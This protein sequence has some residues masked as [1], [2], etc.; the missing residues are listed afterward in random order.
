MLA[1][2]TGEVENP[3]AIGWAFQGN[4][5]ILIECKASRSDFLRDKKKISRRTSDLYKLG[6]YRYYL[7]PP[8][9]VK[10]EEL[11]PGWGLLETSGS[12]VSIIKIAERQKV[13]SV[14]REM[15]LLWSELAKYQLVWN[16][17]ELW[18]CRAKAEIE[19]TVRHCMAVEA[20]GL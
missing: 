19:G 11:F 10:P 1:E 4:T 6:R 7:T 17:A 12:K 2:R 18:Q 16:G 15:Q 14:E 8:K 20:G 3:D 13:L 5:S 9:I